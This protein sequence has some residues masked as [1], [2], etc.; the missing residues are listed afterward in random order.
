[1]ANQPFLRGV[2]RIPKAQWQGDIRAFQR[3]KRRVRF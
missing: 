3:R 1:M 2:Q